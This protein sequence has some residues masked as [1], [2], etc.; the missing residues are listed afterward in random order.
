MKGQLDMNISSFPSIVGILG[1]Y[2]ILIIQKLKRATF[3]TH[4]GMK[5]TSIIWSCLSSFKMTPPRNHISNLEA[6]MKLE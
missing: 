6:M 4:F 5:N 3:C 2:H 1:Y